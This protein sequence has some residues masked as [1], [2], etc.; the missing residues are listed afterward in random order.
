MKALLWLIVLF[1]AG[2]ALSVASTMFGGNVYFAVGN[3]LARV[4]LKLFVP[5]LIVAVV[6]LYIVIQLLGG[7]FNVPA[8]LQRFGTVRKGRKA[9][10]NL[11][12]AGLA[13]FEGKYQKAEQEAAKV[14][15]NKEAGESRSLALMIAAHAADRMNDAAL[16]DRYLHE[17]AAL[18]AAAQLSRYLM[19]AE[20]ALNRRDYPAAEENLAAAAKIS[21]RLTRLLRLQLR[22]AFDHGDAAEVLDKT[23]DLQKQNAA[24]P[25]E[26]AQY[27]DWAYRRLLAEASDSDG[28]KRVLKRI[29]DEMKNG[30]LCAAVAEKYENLGL[31]AAAAAWVEKHYPQNGRADLL[32]PFVRSASFLAD[33]DRLK[34]LDAAEG[35][36]KTRQKDA[37]L[38]LAL[39]Q[40]A[41][42]RQLWGKAQ[43]YLEAAIAEHDSPQARLALA[44]VFDKTGDEAAAQ[45]QRLRALTLGEPELSLPAPQG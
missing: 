4:D 20:D 40:L 11:N 3:T 2:V 24:N 33:K 45:E 26:A 35:W 22:Y 1:A 23:D 38:L 27:R 9:G 30:A 12:A 19:L 31:Y 25:H 15:A 7:L 5:A 18:P 13:Y 29:P 28:L 37:A 42:N 17:I 10:S 43:G 39:G 6:L 44:K 32:P 21:P 41:E 16:R 36:L 14:L 8:R 34:A